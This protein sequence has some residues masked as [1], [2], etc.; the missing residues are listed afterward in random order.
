MSV[1]RWS[2]SKYPSARNLISSCG[3]F[4]RLKHPTVTFQTL[5]PHHFSCTSSIAFLS[6]G[7]HDFT[8]RAYG[9]NVIPT[10]MNVLPVTERNRGL[11]VFFCRPGL[12][13]LL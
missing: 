12:N 8:V 6:A 5:L 2:V 3:S 10:K 1:E 7:D 11:Q 9:L 13:P 4:D